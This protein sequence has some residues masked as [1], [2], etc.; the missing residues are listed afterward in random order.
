MLVLFSSV[1]AEFGGR[2]F[3][4]YSSANGFLNG[5][6]DH[7]GRERGHPVQSISWSS[8]AGIGMNRSSP[9]D[10][11]R[12]RGFQAITEEAGISLLTD[13][14]ALGCPNLIA[15]LDP[16]N[17]HIVREM[18]PEQL[19]AAEI[20]LAYTAHEE[21]DEGTLRGALSGAVVNGHLPVR[22]IRLNQLPVDEAGRADG[23][24]LL[25]LIP[26]VEA[27]RERQ[28]AVVQTELERQLAT[29]WS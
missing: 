24:Q 25:A 20:I 11:A 13:A 18:V 8:W 15:G 19:D 5:F 16:R 23:D 1:N 29:I 17:V 2:S 4:A 10:A 3:G 22:F 9:A 27:P 21:I 28:D 26:S 6:A 7:W 14:L 12:S